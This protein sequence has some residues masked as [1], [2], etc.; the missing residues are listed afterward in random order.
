MSLKTI[1]IKQTSMVKKIIY[2][3]L[4]LL[5]IY[6]MLK[7]GV[8]GP[9]VSQNGISTYYLAD[10]L[11]AKYDSDNNGE[12][13]VSDESFLR[14]KSDH[15]TKVES[16][17]LLFTEADKSGNNDGVAT[18]NELMDFLDGYDTDGDG[19]LT[20]YKNIIDSILNGKSEWSRFDKEY[21]ERYKY[22]DN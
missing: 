20:T 15:I 12:L 16:R 13:S 4:I 19:E 3:C 9:I 6:L 5:V 17:G 21:G 10:Q 7:E 14:T 2:I 22:E 18:L 11:L 1:S 8:S